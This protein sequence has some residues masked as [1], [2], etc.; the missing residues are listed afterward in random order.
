MV[1]PDF[2]R[3]QEYTFL[4]HKWGCEIFDYFISIDRYILLGQHNSDIKL[5]VGACAYN[6]T[7]KVLYLKLLDHK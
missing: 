1:M 2:R 4:V 5:G 6:W 3:C 7:R